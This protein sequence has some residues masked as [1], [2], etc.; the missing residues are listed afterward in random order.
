VNSRHQYFINHKYSNLVST[1]RSYSFI[2]IQSPEGK[3]L[4]LSFLFFL[5]STLLFSLLQQ[6]ILDA[7]VVVSAVGLGLISRLK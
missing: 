5:L 3:F 7:A 2:L 1:R 6:E 4:F